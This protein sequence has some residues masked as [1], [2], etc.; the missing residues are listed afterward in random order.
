MSATGG[1]AKANQFEI[2]A[3]TLAGR[4]SAAVEKQSIATASTVAV[5]ERLSVLLERLNMLRPPGI[6]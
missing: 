2:V 4:S 5:E 3:K 6:D 1:R